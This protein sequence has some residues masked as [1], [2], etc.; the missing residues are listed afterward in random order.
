MRH[1][2]P[3]LRAPPVMHLTERKTNTAK[4]RETRLASKLNGFLRFEDRSRMGLARAVLRL[5][6]RDAPGAGNRPWTAC[7]MTLCGLF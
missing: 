6:P 7:A 4:A 2:Y 1:P 5:V 3:T